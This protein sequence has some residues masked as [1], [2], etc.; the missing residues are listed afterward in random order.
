MTS[1]E[2]KDDKTDTTQKPVAASL[3]GFSVEMG[4]H[5]LDSFRAL[6]HRLPVGT[7][8]FLNL[9]PKDELEQ[10]LEICRQIR[11]LGWTPI[12]HL[13]ARRARST[14]DVPRILDRF[15]SDAGVRDFLIIAGDL[16][17]PADDI[18]DS[19]DFIREIRSNDFG[20]RRIEISG[21]PEGHPLISDQELSESQQEKIHLLRELGIEPVVVTQ[22]SFEPDAIIRYCNNLH[23]RYPDLQLKIGL[24][25]PA[26][27]TTLI[28]FAQRCGVRSSMKKI[29]ALPVSTSLQLLQRVSPVKQAEAI[30]KYRVE[31]NE[32]VTVH[33]FTFG[34]LEASLDWIDDELNG[35]GADMKV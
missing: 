34:G 3:A 18:R 33:L 35:A 12:P 31:Q 25:G 23:S 24:P 5:E 4:S 27:L 32:N 7:E 2:V 28:R 14:A 30:G 19:L 29:K 21:Y 26:K 22:F 16:E 15:T 9:F 8:V 10:Q 1:I 17:E 6:A 11:A 13:A 20:I